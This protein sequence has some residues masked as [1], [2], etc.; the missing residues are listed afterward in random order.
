MHIL[1]VLWIDRDELQ[2][3]ESDLEIGSVGLE[4]VE[5]TS[6][7]GLELRRVL[8]RGRGGDDLVQLRG[9]HFD[10]WMVDCFR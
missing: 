1:F 5:S 10:C 3:S 8:A 4:I 7:A 2:R 9:G 6:D